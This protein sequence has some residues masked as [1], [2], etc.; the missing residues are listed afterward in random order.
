MKFV[1][2][3]QFAHKYIEKESIRYKTELKRYN[4]VTPTSF[5]SLLHSFRKILNEKVI[6]NSKAIER[7]KNG[8]D[9]L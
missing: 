7:L 5:L 8:I 9:R 2:F 1:N 3:F 4:Y 6:E